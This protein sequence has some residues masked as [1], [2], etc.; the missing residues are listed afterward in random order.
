MNYKYSIVLYGA[1]DWWVVWA[2][3]YL[4]EFRNC[5]SWVQPLW[6]DKWW[7]IY[8]EKIQDRSQSICKSV[9]VLEIYFRASDAFQQLLKESKT[10]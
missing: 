9:F 2:F 3:L 7:N 6:H 8:S 1:Q 5:F 10:L 4:L